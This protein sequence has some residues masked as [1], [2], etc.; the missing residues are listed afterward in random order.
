MG[1]A[2]LAFLNRWLLYMCHFYWI[3]P[4]G[5]TTSDRN[6]ELATFDSTVHNWSRRSTVP[7]HSQPHSALPE[8]FGYYSSPF[9][10]NIETCAQPS[11]AEHNHPQ[12][13]TTISDHN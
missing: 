2:F 5:S 3:S 9:Q 11:R 6:N 13:V 12:L 7:L 1:P 8:F 10:Y 4:T